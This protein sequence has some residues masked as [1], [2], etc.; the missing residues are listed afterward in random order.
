MNPRNLI[1]LIL[2]GLTLILALMIAIK[3]GQVPEPTITLTDLDPVDITRITIQRLAKAEIRLERQDS[4]WQL[5]APIEIAANR[6][7]INSLLRL[8]IQD[9]IA[10]YSVNELDLAAYGLDPALATIVLN[11]TKISVGALNPVTQRRY[12]MIDD[13]VHIV[14]DNL[15]DLYSTESASY[16]ATRLVTA[17]QEIKHLSLPWLEISKTQHDHWEVSSGAEAM[18]PNEPSSVVKHWQNA[19]AQWVQPYDGNETPSEVTVTLGDGHTLNFII[20][21]TQPQLVLAR[22]ELQLQYHMSAERGAQLLPGWNPEQL[23]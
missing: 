18:L 10:R 15:Y 17:E 19:S 22:P 2:L 8:A 7:P 9:S 11:N 4:G 23:P 13:T 3:P 20:T 5:I 1:N 14:N 21:A 12:F 16:V 6:I